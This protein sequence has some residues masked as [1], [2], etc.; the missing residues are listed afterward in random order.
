MFAAPVAKPK[1][2]QPQDSTVLSQR[3]GQ[4]AVSQARVL[5]QSIGNPAIPWLPAQCATAI[6][7]EPDV[8]EKEN[9]AARMAARAVAPLHDFSKIPVFSPD[10]TARS[11]NPPP[12]PAPRLSGPV[13][14]KLKIGAVD[15]PLKSEAD[16]AADQ[17]MRTPEPRLQRRCT[18]GGECPKCQAEK[19]ARG[20]ARL[21]SN[22]V[23]SV[24]LGQKAAPPIIHDVLR[25][26]G[27]PL[28]AG[29]RAFMEP[30]FGHDFSQVRVHTDA[31]AGL[32]ARLIDAEAYTVGNDIAFAA[33]RFD[34]ASQAGRGLLAHEL[35]HTLQQRNAIHARSADAVS[36]A[37]DPEER[38]ADAA[39]DAVLADRPVPELAAAAPVVARSPA[40]PAR[41][42]FI[43]QVVVDKPVD[44]HE[45]CIRAV[46]QGHEIERP[47]AERL[48]K[49]GALHCY[50]W[51]ATRGVGPDWVGA[52]IPFWVGDNIAARGADAP[53]GSAADVKLT[54]SEEEEIDAETNQRF[55]ARIGD[56]RILS[57][58]DPRDAAYRELWKSER[59]AVLRE[60]HPA[61]AGLG[62]EADDD[63]FS[64]KL[65]LF[66]RVVGVPAAGAMEEI[67][68]DQFA[69][70]M[71]VQD[72]LAGLTERDW[73]RLG[74]I[75]RPATADWQGLAAWLSGFIAEQRAAEGAIEKVRHMD[76][77]G[78]LDSAYEAI[79]G[80]GGGSMDQVEAQAYTRS[81]EFERAAGE[82]RAVFRVRA[83]E[84]AAQMLVR[85]QNA[86]QVE[87]Q[88]MESR[89]ERKALF[90]ALASSQISQLLDDHPIFR[91]PETLRDAYNPRTAD[92]LGE[93]LRGRAYQQAERIKFLADH[94][95]EKPDVVF[96]LDVVVSA[97]LA[98][99]GLAKSVHALIIQ[100][101][102]GAS[103]G[104]S[105]FDTLREIGLIVLMLI[106]GVNVVV[107]VV[108][109]FRGFDEAMTDY[110]A[111]KDAFRLG[112]RTTEP[113]KTGVVVAGVGLAV[114]VL[115]VAH[116]LST[117]ARDVGQVGRLGAMEADVASSAAVTDAVAGGAETDLAAAR[118]DGDVAPGAG[119]GEKA[120]GAGRS[121]E[122]L[123]P[124]EPA[125][126]PVK[127]GHH[128]EV[129]ERGIE[130]CSPGPC[131]LLRNEYAAELRENEVLSR[132]LDAIDKLR[133]TEPVQ[134]AR[135]AAQL[136]ESL[137][138]IRAHGELFNQLPAHVTDELRARLAQLLDTAEEAGIRLSPDQLGEIAARL[139]RTQSAADA[140]RAIAG[141]RSDLQ[142]AVDLK[143]A[144][145]LRV[146]AEDV[147]APGSSG[148]E[149]EGFGPAALSPLERPKGAPPIESQAKGLVGE[150]RH[151]AE[152]SA[153]EVR[154]ADSILSKATQQDMRDELLSGRISLRGFLRRFQ[155]PEGVRQVLL[156][157]SQGNRI[158]DHMYEEAEKVVLRESKN[159]T[160]FSIGSSAR[161]QIDKDLEIFR[162]FP[163]ARVEWRISGSVDAE[164]LQ[165]LELLRAENPGGFDFVLDQP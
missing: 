146:G 14:A 62:G 66:A 162:R 18:C 39:A 165:Q 143:Q 79:H 1:A 69:W 78:G 135:E 153:T 164:T 31:R 109:G 133:A 72:M 124:I 25:S 117:V 88:R 21:Q 87:R 63:P 119:A 55:W 113:S 118:T 83:L 82:F 4:S 84:V 132:R 40:A 114:N 76:K 149:D 85:A 5:Q 15:D 134:A 38:A 12:Y 52:R 130:V 151:A 24:D 145:K 64:P 108:Q 28:D 121:A 128:V 122:G 100:E 44:G 104:S 81:E 86:M 17:V 13:Q 23:G 131:P 148:V 35:A 158:I 71:Q 46:M 97:T 29:T 26:P 140:E 32:A 59:E 150:A 75:R 156:P 36:R 65:R 80:M 105:L 94:L 154:E 3:P 8:H 141:L 152:L 103:D 51:P 160:E 10:C 91:D 34:P 90:A 120:A 142:R 58:D 139:G 11:R 115:P 116:E 37:D 56:F 147:T 111:N 47:E 57:K 7:N 9:D 93:W 144:Q 161:L 138:S 102:W 48:L 42:G 159:F 89:T 95:R 53:T 2:M 41:R 61:G 107:G 112:L 68:P 123:E 45:F 106:P 43:I 20:H 129:S 74:R 6:R 27:Q 30:P 157:T 16:R 101:G 54:R 163:E 126:E 50:G 73:A 125:R 60:R 67:A 33:G 127:G 99:L 155:R 70:M 110:G 92:D 49:S 136:R 22:H 98:E 19:L 77:F 96:A 137:E